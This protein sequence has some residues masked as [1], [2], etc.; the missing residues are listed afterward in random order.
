MMGTLRP[1]LIFI[2]LLLTG[3]QSWAQTNYIASETPSAEW[4]NDIQLADVDGDGLFDLV[5]PQWTPG[6]GRQL[7]IHQ[8]Q[9][10]HRFPARPTRTVDI[11]PEIVAV[12]FADV[13][14]E[15][16]DELL[17]FTGTSVFSLST[18]QA[19][20][21]GNIRHLFDWPLLT[22]VP[23]RRT[24]YFLQAPTDLT[25]NGYVD[26][27]LPGTDGYGYFEGQG[28]ESFTLRQQFTTENLELDRSL[29]PPPAG[30]FST[31]VTF[32]EQDGLVVRVI[33]RSASDFEGFVMDLNDSAADTLLETEQWMPSAVLADMRS[34]GS[35]DV[36]FL[37]IG[38]DLYGQVNI[39]SRDEL[40]NGN[41]TPVWQGPVEMEGDFH[42][43]HLNGDE[44]VDLARVLESGEDWDVHLYRNQGGR[45]DLRQPDQVMRF[46]GYD[47]RLET[48][49]VAG[50]G[51]RQLSITYYTIPVVNAI[52]NASIVRSQLLY[53][54]A[55]GAQVFNSRP[56]FRQDDSFSAQTI[57]GLTSPIH[58]QSDLDGDGRLDALYLTDAGVLTAR[59]IDGRLNFEPQPFWQYVPSRTILDFELRDL[60]EDSVPDILLY[61]SNTITMLVSAP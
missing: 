48:L 9:A 20:Y 36:V 47:L 42:L 56:D 22:A 31:E 16:G 46:S 50:D 1:P 32:N 8:Q 44:L 13:R 43:L 49:D 57:R 17:L 35:A 23:Q 6:I 15:P 25:G 10:D 11:R 59:R 53:G 29:L 54:S 51:Q 21:A 39:L 7:L 19:T 5:I 40:A 37:N 18:A 33:P 41:T 34:E 45:F 27:L 26:L 12:A 58:L 3:S 14:E 52:R 24:T 30:R 38:N 60:N 2:A 28:Q 61:H 4:P 55:T